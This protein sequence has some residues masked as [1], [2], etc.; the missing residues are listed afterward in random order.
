MIEVI[1]ATNHGI[2]NINLIKRL[3][4]LSLHDNLGSVAFLSDLFREVFAL[5]LIPVL[6]KTSG[7]PVAIGVCG[8]TCMDVTLPVIEKHANEHDTLV[9][10]ISGAIITV[11]VPFLIP[12]FYSL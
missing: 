10:F 11:A 7:A 4:C 6:C 1:T 3:S 2:T 9:A 5:L 12:F 8:A